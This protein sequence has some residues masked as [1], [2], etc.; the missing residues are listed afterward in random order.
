MSAPAVMPFVDHGRS[1]HTVVCVSF[2]IAS[3]NRQKDVGTEFRLAR[4]MAESV[5]DVARAGAHLTPQTLCARDADEAAA[6]LADPGD[7]LG[8]GGRGERSENN[9]GAE[10]QTGESYSSH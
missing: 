6:A 8:R 4:A 10:R 5:G 7:M 3:A 9:E 1:A 2:A